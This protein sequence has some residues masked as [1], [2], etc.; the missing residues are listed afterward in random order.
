M[1]LIT[2]LF[3]ESRW[4]PGVVARAPVA[5]TQ[6]DDCNSAYNHLYFHRVSLRSLTLRGFNL[7]AAAA[8][9]SLL[10]RRKKQ[11]FN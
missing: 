11:S 5:T 1:N 8:D 10:K 7:V 2:G 4:G 9:L 6:D 3:N